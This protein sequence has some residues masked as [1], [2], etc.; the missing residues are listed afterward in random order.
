[1][2]KEIDLEFELHAYVDGDLDDEA[3]ARVESYLSKNPDI[4]TKARDYLRQKDDLRRFARAQAT[5]EEPPALRALGKKL[6]R[7][8][9]ISNFFPWRRAMAMTLLFLAGWLGHVFY[10]P[11]VEGPPYTL[12]LLQAHELTAGDPAEILPI[13]KD[14]VSKL[15]SRIG[16]RE[17]IPD[18]RKF[19]LEPI[20]AQL[21]PSHE[22]LVLHVP[23]RDSTGA[24]VSYFLLHDQD[25][26]ELPRHILHKKGIT[27]VYWQHDHSRYAITSSLTDEQLSSIAAFVDSN[28]EDPLLDL[29]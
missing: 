21:M 19:G 22:G 7:R 20:G 9:R 26:A 29:F 2:R 1:M 16:E 8:L 28:T 24:V 18:L 3:M 11:L 23:Y 10:V 25:Q 5:T 14:R 27:M 17:R 15:F 13:S 6:A 4:A 12:E